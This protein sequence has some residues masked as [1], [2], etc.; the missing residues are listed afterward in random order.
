MVTAGC[1]SIQT[2]GLMQEFLNYTNSGR[3]MISQ[4]AGSGRV[5]HE[6]SWSMIQWWS[7]RARVTRGD[8]GRPGAGIWLV[9]GAQPWC[10]IGRWR[11]TAGHGWV[12]AMSGM[13]GWHLDRDDSKHNQVSTQLTMHWH[14][15]RFKWQ[16]TSLIFAHHYIRKEPVLGA[17][18]CRPPGGWWWWPCLG[19]GSAGERRAGAAPGTP[20]GHNNMPPHTSQQPGREARH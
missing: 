3:A 11:H 19:Q 2:R 13:W 6:E 15:A 14:W 12:N 8:G 18:L 9:G 10:L 16:N 1:H 7:A 20:G 4:C 5:R 17:A